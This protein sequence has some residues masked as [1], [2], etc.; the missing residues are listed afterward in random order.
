MIPNLELVAKWLGQVL[1]AGGV[2]LLIAWLIMLAVRTPARRITIAE[3]ALR[4]ALLIPLFAA[5]PSWWSVPRPDFSAKTFVASQSR[6]EINEQPGIAAR[7]AEQAESNVILLLPGG[8]AGI[9]SPAE[10]VPDETAANVAPSAPDLPA[11]PAAVADRASISIPGLLLGGYS[12]VTVLLLLRWLAGHLALWRMG[13]K[14]WPA[15]GRAARIMDELTL[16]RRLPP[17][18]RIVSGLRVPVCFGLWRPTILLPQRVAEQSDETALRCVLAHELA[19]LR[20]GDAWTCF[21]AGLA[22][23]VY[24][25]LPWLWMLHRQLRLCQEYRAD[26][27]AAEAA[28]RA[29]DYAAFLVELSRSLAVGSRRYAVATAVLGNPSDLFRRIT[30]LLK[31]AYVSG[32]ASRPW[33]LVAAGGFLSLAV[34]LAG[35][36]F[37]TPTLASPAKPDEPAKADEKKDTPKK[38]DAKKDNAKKSD[39]EKAPARP[40]PGRPRVIGGDNIPEEYKKF[41]EKMMEEMMKRMEDRGFPGV[42]NV[43]RVMGVPGLG[44]ANVR[45]SGRLG[46]AVEKPSAAL[47]EHLDLPKDQGLVIGEVTAD[48]AASKAGL[49]A[50]DI[51]LEINGK[52]VAN[53]VAAFRKQLAE[54][55]T[56]APVDAVIMRKGKRESIKGIKLPE[57]K[58]ERE[59]PEF[60]DFDFGGPR[61]IVP[62]IPLP[63]PP[64]PFAEPLGGTG[65]QLSVQMTNGRFTI[66][67][68]KD[69]LTIDITGAVD[70]GATT[71]KSIT[72]RD[73]DESHTATS[74]EKLPEKYRETVNGLLKNVQVKKK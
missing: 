32:R 70:D 1:I 68:Q 45:S 72:V 12:L 23:I 24:W 48:S 22:Q 56:D 21:V 43:P 61:V 41:V 18:L 47:V 44:G 2:V 15:S 25:P 69:G 17:R 26:A 10:P 3:W 36:G 54:I 4:A 65:E 9:A 66:H 11:E 20:H 8:P 35:F 37:S 28:G 5:L 71:I 60:P 13:R 30:M 40:F 16:G 14:S 39:E 63:A 53:D 59:F 58:A 62:Q 57:A 27:A 64:A 19:H 74:V 6:R 38:D 7:T 49:K 42:P 50:N 31:N 29:E 55:K 73:G 51:L 67:S 34:L 33:S 52:P 46:V